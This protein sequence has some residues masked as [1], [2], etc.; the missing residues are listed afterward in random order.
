MHMLSTCRADFAASSAS[1]CTRSGWT[2]PAGRT[3]DGKEGVEHRAHENGAAGVRLEHGFVVGGVRL[4][5]T[6][7]VLLLVDIPAQSGAQGAAPAGRAPE[8]LRQLA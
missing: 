7:L 6:P 1:R 4:G 8:L 5:W 2:A 3:V